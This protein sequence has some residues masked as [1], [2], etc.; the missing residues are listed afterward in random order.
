MSSGPTLILI[1]RDTYLGRIYPLVKLAWVFLVAVFLFVFRSPASGATMFIALIA[2]ALIGGGVPLSRIAKS[3][4]FILL[5][6]VLLMIFHLFSDPGSVAY[7]VGP[8]RVTDT[9]LR[10]GP[11]FFF[12]LSVI[13]LASFILI[14]TTDTRD[15]MASLAKAGMPYRYAYAV[16]LALRFLPLIQ[17]EVDAVRDAHRIRGR[18]AKTSISHRMRL[19]GRYVF[20]V[21]INGLRKAETTS[22]SLETRA[23]GVFPTRSYM[24][25]PIF[26]RRDL[27]L[28][29]LTLV[30]G[31]GLLVL[32]H[33]HW[34]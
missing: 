24:K 2:L 5:L 30:I 27:A 17:Q 15:L 1:N 14:W 3:G 11:V 31:V 25:E 4:R 16:F 22:V 23:F 26:H 32:E 28:V 9:G 20:T 19:W 33:V 18:A 13:V 10:L 6:G 34:I 7:R 8:I 21:L 29:V 12:R